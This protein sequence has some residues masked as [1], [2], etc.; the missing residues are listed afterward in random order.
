M[1]AWIPRSVIRAVDLGRVYIKTWFYKKEL[2]PRLLKAAAN[3]K[4]CNTMSTEILHTEAATAAAPPKTGVAKARRRRPIT[5]RHLFDALTFLATALH[6]EFDD[7][8]LTRVLQSTPEQLAAMR[9]RLID[10]IEGNV[11]DRNIVTG[12]AP[13]R[14]TSVPTVDQMMNRI[15]K[16]QLERSIYFRRSDK[17]NATL[18]ARLLEMPAGTEAIPAYAYSVQ[19]REPNGRTYLMGYSGYEVVQ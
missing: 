2:Q 5:Q 3:K 15:V 9:R 19:V 6:H 12:A 16:W 17:E 14:T 10:A 11:P 8:T 13:A 4:R 1:T 7:E 18:R